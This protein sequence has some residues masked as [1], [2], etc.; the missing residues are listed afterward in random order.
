MLP[1]VIP[2][3]RRKEYISDLNT[4]NLAALT[5]FAEELQQLEAKRYQ[6]MPPGGGQISRHLLIRFLLV[7]KYPY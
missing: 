5:A 1:A 3:E 7:K 6:A 2:V 4:E